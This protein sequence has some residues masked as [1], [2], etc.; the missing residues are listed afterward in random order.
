MKKFIKFRVVLLIFLA[1]F[2]TLTACQSQKAI[3]GEKIKSIMEQKGYTVTDITD[4]SGT[5]ATL[6]LKAEMMESGSTA[7]YNIRFFVFNSASEA[8]SVFAEAKD[9]FAVY[10]DNDAVIKNTDKTNFQRYTLLG[11]GYY[12]L[13]TRIDNTLLFTDSLNTYKDDI[14]EIAKKLGY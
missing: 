2:F 3:S 14:I 12:T 11:Q 7:S 5:S 8:K 1:G 4:N 6:A 9:S 10:E 13:I